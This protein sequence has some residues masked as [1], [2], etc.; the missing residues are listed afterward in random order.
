MHGVTHDHVYLCIPVD[1]IDLSMLRLEKS[2]KSSF[3]RRIRDKLHV[4]RSEEFTDYPKSRFHRELDVHRVMSE[5]TYIP[6]SG[7]HR[8]SQSEKSTL[9]SET[10]YTPK[11]G[12]LISI[13]YIMHAWLYN[14]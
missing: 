8:E 2:T 4:H 5:S 3:R 13:L 10:S 7:F 14:N 9:V 1:G 12:N 6:E 11:Q